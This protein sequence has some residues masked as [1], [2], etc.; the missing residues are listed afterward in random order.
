MIARDCE[1]FKNGIAVI[2]WSNYFSFLNN[3]RQALKSSICIQ[4]H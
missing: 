4:K 1:L 3:T 2:E